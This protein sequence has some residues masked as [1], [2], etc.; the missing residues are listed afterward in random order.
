MNIIAFIEETHPPSWW[1]VFLIQFS[2]T[3]Y[4]TEFSMRRC[5]TSLSLLAAGIIF[6]ITGNASGAMTLDSTIFITDVRG[7]SMGNF[8]CIGDYLLQNGYSHGLKIIRLS[9]TETQVQFAD[10]SPGG[11]PKFGVDAAGNWLCALEVERNCYFYYFNG[12]AVTGPLK[13]LDTVPIIESFHVLQVD[14]ESNETFN[15]LY[16]YGTGYD[17]VINSFYSVQ[18]K[19]GNWG[20]PSLLRRTT[21][22]CAYELQGIQNKSVLII[23]ELDSVCPYFKSGSSW[24]PLPCIRRT[25]RVKT[26]SASADL[27]YIMFGM[28]EPSHTFYGAFYSDSLLSIDSI[29]YDFYSDDYYWLGPSYD[30]VQNR[31][32]AFKGLY[33]TSNSYNGYL[34]AFY[35][36]TV[37]GPRRNESI[38]E[39]FWKPP[40]RAT[41]CIST[42]SSLRATPTLFG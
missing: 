9:S 26:V 36:S 24:S 20:N 42:G 14:A 39:F 15:V 38:R 21:G 10:T 3:T 28:C 7:D 33:R 5:T 31:F 25:E 22:W 27:R 35:K 32:A 2:L 29:N 30:P 1:I 41:M 13:F 19:N 17:P 23:E 18:F 4:G 12:N 34:E 16:I 11:N 6:F 37:P 8:Y 40:S